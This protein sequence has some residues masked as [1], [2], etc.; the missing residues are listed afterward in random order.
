[1]LFENGRIAE[2]VG[3]Y[4]EA[5]RNRPDSALLRLGLARA[6]IEQGKDADLA[7]AAA[8]LEEVV[9]IEPGNAGAWRFLGIAEG[10]RGR[11]GPAAMAL[12]EQA[13]LLQNREDAELY[14]RRA[15]QLVP[16]D[17]PNWFRLQ[18]LERSVEE[19]EPAAP[20]RRR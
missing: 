13:V 7:E 18:D 11:D 1:M 3:P 4:R 5:V 19:I 6:L 15:R 16:P 20:A 14:V 9:R 12:A 10:R 8:L 2:A 17:D